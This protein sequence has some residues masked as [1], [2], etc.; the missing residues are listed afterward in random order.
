MK[1]IILGTAHQKSIPGKCSPDKKFFEYQ[2]SREIIKSISPVLKD[3]GYNVLIDVIEDDLKLPQNKELQKRVEIVNNFCKKYKDCIYVSIHVNAAGDGTKWMN[4]GGWCAYTS[5]GNTKSDKLAESLYKSAEPNL[6]EYKNLLEE[7][8]KKKLYST[9]QQYI[10]KDKTDGDSDYEANFYVL[11][12]T[13]CPA[14][15]TE[16]L[17]QDNKTDVEFLKSD[18]GFHAICRL[19]IEGIINY[20]KDN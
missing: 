10:R 13:K 12:N 3:L 8:K 16:N 11:K 19:H 18:A 5:K 14:V 7:G 20:L 6:K 4:A 9:S 15:L 1:T 17:F 2:Y